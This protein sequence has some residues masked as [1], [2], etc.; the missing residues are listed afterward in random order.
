MESA[1]PKEADYILY[2]GD[3]LELLIKSSG[4]KIW[5][6]RCIRPFTKKRAKKSIG[7]YPAATLADARNYRAESRSLLAKQIDP[8]EHQQEQLR[9]SLEAKI[10]T[11]QLVAERWWNVKKANAT[12]DYAK[13]IWRSLERDVFPAIGDVSVTDIK[14]HTLVQAR[15]AL[16]TV[17]RLCQRI[18]EVMI[19]AQN[20]GLIDAVPSVNIGKA[21][22][23]PQK[24]NMPSIR[25]DQLPQLMQTMRTASIS[26][27]TRCLF[28]WQ[29]LTITRPAEAAEARWEEVDI[30]AREWKIPAA[31]MKMNRDHTVPL[32]DEA[33]AILE[34][35][36]P[37]SGNREFIFP[38]RIKPN[39]PMNSQTVNASLKRAGFGGV[40]VSHGLR[41]I[42]S[43]ALNE[44]GFPP[45]VI[46]A[47]L[48]HVDKNEV[49]RA[50]NRSDYLEQRRPMMQ[51]W[52]DFIEA[53]DAG[54][55]LA[56][57][58]RGIKLAG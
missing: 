42:A 23:K 39:K 15:G 48:A 7:S 21:F 9:I 1:K 49:R 8:Q 45:D 38:S 11:F 4:N 3:G 31:R 17:R 54:S 2:D 50:Y 20:T 12:E 30:E 5:Q 55:I 57:G 13:D 36:K 6:F 27:S 34:M 51:W 35:M 44:Q 22:E 40:L 43:T 32:S 16:E 47:A 37:L 10:N 19:Y 26:L 56:G 18:N 58:V 14:A 46:E 52:A 41:S 53:A 28:M 29:L 33:I 24:K 25:P